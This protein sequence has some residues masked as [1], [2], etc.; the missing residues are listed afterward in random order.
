MAER[1]QIISHSEDRLYQNDCPVICSAYNILYDNLSEDLLLQAKFE[2]LSRKTISEL[3]LLVDCFDVANNCLYNNFEI[4]Y[5]GTNAGH[6][7]TFGVETAKNL[8]NNKIRKIS[9]KVKS[10]VFADG[11]IWNANPMC[12]MENLPPQIS[13][14]DY[15]VSNELISEYAA[16]APQMYAKGKKPVF[17]E[18]Y[19][20]CACGEVNLND[21]SSCSNCKCV[22]EYLNKIIDKEYLFNSA[23]ERKIKQEEEA[24][25]QAELKA[26]N[27]KK[28]KT[29]FVFSVVIALICII[30]YIVFSSV[31]ANR[32]LKTIEKYLINGDYDDAV[33]FIENIEP[34]EKISSYIV[35][36]SNQFIND[37]NYVVAYELLNAC[38]CP[39]D[40]LNKCILGWQQY[41]L[42]GNYSDY[43]YFIKDV[44]LP[45]SILEQYYNNIITSLKETSVS[46]SNYNSTQLSVNYGFL[47]KMPEDYKDVAKMLDAIDAINKLKVVEGYYFNDEIYDLINSANYFWNFN[48][49]KDLIYNER[50]GLFNFMQ[51]LWYSSDGSYYMKF[52]GAVYD[53]FSTNI[54]GL[55]PI[56]S[57]YISQQEF[58]DSTTNTPKFKIVLNTPSE[59]LV[60]CYPSNKK[61]IMN[62]Y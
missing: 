4:N 15:L 34:S 27:A 28:I 58:W 19:W 26:K 29:I 1:Y 30:S 35:E 41:I 8:P 32:N 37:N 11:S 39:E 33:S 38:N 36:K 6:R 45:D 18:K 56:M 24:K 55:N 23:K 43:K 17:E 57:G 16:L 12:S 2:N 61:Y 31:S 49:L 42:S 21:D 52:E 10:I 13:I 62:R 14:E 20:M 54:P 25:K 47:L 50:E 3:T 5:I 51:G 59:I 53:N 60:H 44:K 7:K 9:I 22:K 40:Q 46:A 48:S